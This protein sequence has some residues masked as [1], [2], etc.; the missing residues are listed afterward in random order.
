MSSQRHS[1][2]DVLPVESRMA[3]AIV[4]QPLEVSAD[5][6]PHVDAQMF[7]S[8]SAC[9]VPVSTSAALGSAV[10]VEQ[11]HVRI[12]EL[13]KRL[14]TERSQRSGAGG[15][16]CASVAPKAP[17]SFAGLIPPKPSRPPPDAAPAVYPVVPSALPGC[18]PGAATV[19][20]RSKAPPPEVARL[21]QEM[22]EMREM[23]GKAPPPGPGVASAVAPVGSAEAPAT[24][25]V[26]VHLG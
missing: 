25:P 14:V 26:A 12:H 2:P 11:L 8:A 23:R 4:E 10:S 21:L 3:R 13:E 19:A 22:Q 7:P 17:V 16:Q 24:P 15:M 18:F 5:L 1:G 6:Q 9:A 20:G